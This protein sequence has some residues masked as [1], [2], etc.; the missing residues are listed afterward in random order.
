MS[1]TSPSHVRACGR[2]LTNN[3][4]REAVQVIK[5]RGVCVLSCW[6]VFREAG[7]ERLWWGMRL[8]SPGT[9]PRL[10]MGSMAV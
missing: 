5:C 4:G 10:P 9:H 6:L 1:Q 3:H 8:L 7:Q 2:A